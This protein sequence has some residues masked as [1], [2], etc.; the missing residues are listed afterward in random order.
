[1]RA[2]QAELEDAER[3]KRALEEARSA[4]AGGPGSRVPLSEAALARLAAE[5]GMEWSK[6]GAGG[7][8]SYSFYNIYRSGEVLEAVQATADSGFSA[9]SAWLKEQ[10]R[11]LEIN[12]LMERDRLQRIAAAEKE[13]ALA[14]LRAALE[15][16]FAVTLAAELQTL[17]FSLEVEKQ[18]AIEK[19]RIEAAA[20][21]AAALQRQEEQMSAA[22][23]AALAQLRSGY[24]AQLESLRAAITALE[25]KHAAA[26]AQAAAAA[27]AEKKAALLAMK[28]D[29]L[30]KYELVRG[31]L[32][33]AQNLSIDGCLNRIEEIKNEA[34]PAPLSHSATHSCCRHQLAQ[35]QA[36]AEAAGV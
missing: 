9:L 1:L 13:A 22:H 19:I 6:E 14:A 26:I 2:A 11:V 8:A 29:F 7:D 4:S 24:E 5:G 15:A 20:A 32:E 21:T 34:R 3:R 18:T 36:E 25:E 33:A 30:A 28:R 17:R 10:Q 16:E 35:F 31:Q 27:A 12:F 23:A